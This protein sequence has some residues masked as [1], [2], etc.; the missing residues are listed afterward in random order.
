MGALLTHLL[1]TARPLA[2]CDDNVR[3]RGL[4]RNR[5]IDYPRA[6]QALEILERLIQTP[7]RERMPCL[8]L[9]GDSNIGKS[10]DNLQVSASSSAR[11]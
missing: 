9:H 4:A 5:W 7:E 2:Q 10:A 11:V 6:T 3:I 8:L 1:P